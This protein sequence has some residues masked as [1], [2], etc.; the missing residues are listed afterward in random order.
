MAL[1]DDTCQ[2]V[3]SEAR[4][5]CEI[6]RK[7]ERRA[8]EVRTFSTYRNLVMLVGL[9]DSLDQAFDALQH[10]VKILLLP[11]PQP[12]V[13]VPLELGRGLV[14]LYPDKFGELGRRWRDK[15]RSFGSFGH[16]E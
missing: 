15:R 10:Q 13:K 7:Q 11:R 1:Y 6:G 8:P 9:V 16:R 3:A 5:R 4:V 12:F 14:P 2:E